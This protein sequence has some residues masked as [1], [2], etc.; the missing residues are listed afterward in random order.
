MTPKPYAQDCTL[1]PRAA[2]DSGARRAR[3][4]RLVVIHS[5][6]S[7]DSFDGDTSAEGVANFFARPSALASTQLA[8]D[9][10][11]CVRMLP[12]LV[13]P[14]GAKGANHD[15][16]HV[17][18][19]GYARWERDEWLQREPMLQRTAFRVAKW[20]WL[21]SIDTRWLTDRQLATVASR[22]LT[23]HAQV[24]KVFKGGDHWDPGD[25]FPEDLF[26]KW[27]KE[28]FAYIEGERSDH[29]P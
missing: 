26:L 25:G 8:V 22:G 16:L 27:V 23:T 13:I 2:H 24:N 9:R 28:E 19:C 21:Y 4:I 17:E 1:G 29:A 20:C 15:G 5:A 10:D 6:E 11:S 12:D 7:A 18:I 14:W 3:A